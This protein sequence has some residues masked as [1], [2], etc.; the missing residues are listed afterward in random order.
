VDS[1]DIVFDNVVVRYPDRAEPALAAL[2]AVVRPGEILA[3]T[4]PSGCGKST[5]L[6]VLLGF[7]TPTAGTVTVGGHPVSAMDPL[8]WR[9][10]IAWVPQRPHLFAGTI[11]ANV[12]LDAPASDVDVRRALDEAGAGLF[13]AQSPLGLD[14]R[15]SDDG[16]G[17]SAGQRQRIALARAFL[18]DAPI[19]LLDEP[20]ANLDAATAATAADVMA[21]IR[22]L[23]RGRTVIVA[24]H[25]PELIALADRVIALGPT[26]SGAFQPAVA[27]AR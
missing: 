19:V 16:A 12:T 6:R 7:A 26:G 10:R 24:A 14:T 20:T 13:V 8:A 15:L 3:L 27:G 18:R 4:G 22:R 23:A 21:G 17:L 5:A 11:R 1:G 2:S 25:R 9:R